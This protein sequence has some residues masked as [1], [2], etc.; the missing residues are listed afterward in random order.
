MFTC[1]CLRA[2]VY[3]LTIALRYHRAVATA[4]CLPRDLSLTKIDDA[5]NAETQK[6]LNQLNLAFYAAN[7]DPF[8]ASRAH[9][10]PGWARALQGIESQ[11]SGEALAVL[12]VG[13]GNGRFAQFLCEK[14]GHPPL[15]F[16]ALAYLGVDQSRELLDLAEEK[17][18]REQSPWALSWLE[19]DILSPSPG[20]GLPPGPFDLIVA[21]G[22]LHHIP[23]LE[24]RKALVA[25]MAGRTR[26]GGRL[27]FTTWRFAETERFTKHRV[28]WGDHNAQSPTPIDLGELEAGDHLL[29]FG[30]EQG[31]PRY[32]HHCDDS[33]F[34]QLAAATGLELVASFLADGRSGDLNRYAILEKRG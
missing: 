17:S 30:S 22:L 33:E 3:V 20:L 10:W 19:S 29:S 1:S 4:P 9:P 31:P 23:G 13:C 14:W 24:Q 18:P 16:P 32:C 6:T 5:M 7:A 28:S 25:E 27:A 34:A 26:V 8:D 15:D 21:F 11:G 12:D 2:H